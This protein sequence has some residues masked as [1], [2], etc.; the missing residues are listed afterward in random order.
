MR[1]PLLGLLSKSVPPGGDTLGGQAVPG[2]TAICTNIST[3]LRSTKLFGPDADTYRPDRFMELQGEDRAALERNVELAF[4]SGQWQC[5]GRV[6]SF[7]EMNKI[8]FEASQDSFFSS[9]RLVRVD[10]YRY[11]VTLIFSWFAL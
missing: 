9:S 7:M 10:F 5:V 3:I 1:P 11:S 4:G 2:G 8:V 6:I